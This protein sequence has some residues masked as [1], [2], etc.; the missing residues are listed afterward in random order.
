MT[1]A[2][3]SVFVVPVMAEQDNGTSDTTVE[4]P[5]S[6]D[7]GDQEQDQGQTQEKTE[8]SGEEQK[9]LYNGAPEK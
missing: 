7:Y 8:G 3:T 5:Q 4:E 2:L 6:G 1:L 9:E